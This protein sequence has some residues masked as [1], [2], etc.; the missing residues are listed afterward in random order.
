MSC[1]A[2]VAAARALFFGG[3]RHRQ[4]DFDVGV[5]MQ[6]DVVLADQPDRAAGQTHFAALD[7]DAG[8]GQRLG[9]V[10]GADRAEELAFAAG[11]GGER[12]LEVL[13][14]RAARVRAA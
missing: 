13:R 4:V 2:I 1:F 3:H 8:G 5:Q 12:E 7:V 9:D 11:L 14:A 6:L 10:G